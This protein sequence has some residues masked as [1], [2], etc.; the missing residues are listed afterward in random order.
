MFDDTVTH[1]RVTKYCKWSE[2]KIHTSAI[3]W[4]RSEFS[5]TWLMM[6]CKRWTTPRGNSSNEQCSKLLP[7]TEKMT[8]LFSRR[9]HASR[10]QRA[11]DATSTVTDKLLYR[12]SLDVGAFSAISARALNTVRISKARTIVAACH[13]KEK[14]V[15]RNER[16]YDGSF[17]EMPRRQ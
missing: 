16:F 4:K 13:W 9:K 1:D 7:C 3:L 6:A 15:A 14:D 5:V 2:N 8:L 12:V 10:M 11:R 17:R